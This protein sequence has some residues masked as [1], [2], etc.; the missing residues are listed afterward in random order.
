MTSP[1]LAAVFVVF[2]GLTF[3]AWRR[4]LWVAGKARHGQEDTCPYSLTDVFGDRHLLNVPHQEG[5]QWLTEI[6]S[7]SAR[8]FPDHT[9]LQIPHTGESLTFA[10]LDARAEAV[11]AALS[12]LLTGPDQVVAVAM[13]QD[14]WQIVASHL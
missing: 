12:P 3:V 9:A 13:A 5:V 2:F 1:T 10:E 7:R 6:F 8:R 4:Y 11:A 14:N